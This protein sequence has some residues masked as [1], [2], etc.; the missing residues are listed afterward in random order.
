MVSLLPQK[1]NTKVFLPIS[2][3]LVKKDYYLVN[4]DY[5]A[6]E[7]FIEPTL[8]HGQRRQV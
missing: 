8:G 5:Y 3:Y 4:S 7:R 2:K 1:M 6:R